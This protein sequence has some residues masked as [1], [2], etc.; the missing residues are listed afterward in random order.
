MTGEAGRSM[1]RLRVIYDAHEVAFRKQ[2][3]AMAA[4]GN[5]IRC[6]RGCD[7][8]C[9]LMVTC[10]IPEALVMVHRMRLDGTLRA[11]IRA[12]PWSAV[13]EDLH[14]D[15]MTTLEWM[16]LEHPCVH[17]DTDAHECRVYE[18]RPAACRGW[19]VVS[20]PA[21]CAIPD[22]PVA[23]PDRRPERDEVL[24]AAMALADDLQI[25]NVMLPL[26][27]AMKWACIIQADGTPALRRAIEGT[28]FANDHA[29]TFY[30]AG[31]EFPDGRTF[32]EDADGWRCRV[33]ATVT[34][35][36][37]GPPRCASCG[38]PHR[39]GAA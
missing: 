23:S 4:E 37:D 15:G 14:R 13:E 27:L 19:A 36:D 35:A 31:M 21:L 3:A 33:C 17:L 16:T 39:T 30:W 12:A 2:E 5:A 11:F 29:I 25:P 34:P 9:R 26:A 28:A 7:A 22:S 18:A 24:L 32:E 10:S 20:D 8:C 6:V 1:L 38:M